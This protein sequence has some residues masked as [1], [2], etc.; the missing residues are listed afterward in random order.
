[1]LRLQGTK[2]PFRVA[3][4]FLELAGD[5]EEEEGEEE[6]WPP[7]PSLGEEMEEGEEEEDDDDDDDDDDAA[8]DGDAD[9]SSRGVLSFWLTDMWLLAMS[10]DHNKRRRDQAAHSIQLPNWS[11][12]APCEIKLIS[13]SIPSL[14]SPTGIVK[15]KFQKRNP[16]SQQTKDD[17]D[18]RSS[19]PRQP[20]VNA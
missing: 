4:W 9:A 16:F 2:T 15:L 19:P 14:V 12:L 8:K 17:E 11:T 7:R 20:H 1:M 5:P 6:P 3:S 10:Q 13:S 18:T